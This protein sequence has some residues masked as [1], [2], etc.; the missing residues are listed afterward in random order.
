MKVVFNMSQQVS[1]NRIRAVFHIPYGS[2]LYKYISHPLMAG[3]KVLPNIGDTLVLNHQED[4]DTFIIK[5]IKHIVNAENFS[6]LEQTFTLKPHHD[7]D[8]YLELTDTE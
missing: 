4:S 7:I 2:S 1:D 5:S 8:I 6:A 3:L